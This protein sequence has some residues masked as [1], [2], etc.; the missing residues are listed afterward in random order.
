MYKY[1]LF[2]SIDDID[3]KHKKAQEGL[4]YFMFVIN[5]LFLSLTFGL[6]AP[7]R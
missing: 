5:V 2:Q 4:G 3:E 1:E 7:F 6:V